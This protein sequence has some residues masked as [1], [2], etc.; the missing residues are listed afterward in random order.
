M[1]LIAMG[2]S[3]SGKTTVG[4]Q[5]AAR[6]HCGFA[7]ADEFHSEANKK[8]MHE[9]HPLTDED[10]WPWLRSIREAIEAKRAAGVDFVFACS[11]LKVVYRDILRAGDKDVVFVYL[12][13]T[14]EVLATR[15]GARKGHFFDPSLLQSQLDTL[16]PPTE[17]EAIF[18]D[19]D[20][21]PEQVVDEIVE[22]VTLRR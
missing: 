19:I 12:H 22:K 11:A 13:G 6:L 8:K 9:G 7:D 1:I 18:V 4:E 14:R 3:G 21:T 16:E 5:L 10:R 17:E 15:L 20:Q 2:V